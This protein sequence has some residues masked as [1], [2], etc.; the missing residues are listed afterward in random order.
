AG[1]LSVRRGR[2]LGA[3]MAHV[4]AFVMALPQTRLSSPGL[5]PRH[6]SLA[7]LHV[8]VLF[9][10]VA[11]ADTQPGGAGAAFGLICLLAA[12]SGL[13]RVIWTWRRASRAEQ[14]L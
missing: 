11:R 5:W 6:A 2:V 8:R 4:G 1:C 13:A 10:S 12:L 14:L 3:A 7:W 9:G